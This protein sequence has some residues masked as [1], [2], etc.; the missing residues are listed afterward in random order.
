MRGILVALALAASAGAAW[1]QAPPPMLSGPDSRLVYPETVPHGQSLIVSP[2]VLRPYTPADLDRMRRAEWRL[3][4]TDAMT[5]SEFK[6]LI[7]ARVQ[8]DV[9]AGISPEAL[10]AKTR[11]GE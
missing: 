10:E 3:L 5:P 4:G 9:A 11:E 2:T 6:M 8:T 7:E 1:G